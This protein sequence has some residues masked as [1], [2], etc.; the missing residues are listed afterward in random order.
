MGGMAR[1]GFLA[2]VLLASRLFFFPQGGQDLHVVV[3]PCVGFSAR[4]VGACHFRFLDGG[5]AS[6]PSLCTCAC[7]SPGGR[8][9]AE[10]L[11]A[12]AQPWRG[13]FCCLQTPARS[14]SL[15]VCK[16]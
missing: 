11:H 3:Q 13:I 2:R 5:G 6:V 16:R 8:R 12:A 4:S 15:F 14:Q 7:P 9:R 10:S 1:R